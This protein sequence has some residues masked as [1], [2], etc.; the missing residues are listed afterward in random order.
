MEGVVVN[1]ENT[2]TGDTYTTLTDENGNYV[3]GQLPAGNYTVSIDQT[4]LPGGL[5]NSTDPDLGTQHEASLTLGSG[6]INLIQ[7][8]GYL[9]DTPGS[10]GNLVWNDVNANGV[11]DA[12]EAGIGDVTLQLYVDS[13]QDGSYDDGNQGCLANFGTNRR[14]NAAVGPLFKCA[15]LAINCAFEHFLFFDINVL[16]FDLDCSVIFDGKHSRVWVTIIDK[17]S[18]NIFQLLWLIEADFPKRATGVVNA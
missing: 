7:D 9:P 10:I 6:E 13:N 17:E 3:F 4:T 15:Y 12:G 1:L 2:D 8:F 16:E 5:T 14:S 18:S 11:V